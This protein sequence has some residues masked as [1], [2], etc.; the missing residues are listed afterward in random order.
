[1][2]LRP[3]ELRRRLRRERVGAP[4]AVRRRRPLRD[5]RRPRP[6]AARAAPSHRAVHDPRPDRSHERAHRW[7]PEPPRDRQALARAPAHAAAPPRRGRDDLQR[8]PRR[9]APFTGAPAPRGRTAQ[10]RRDRLPARVLATERVRPRL[11][12]LDRD[13]AEPAPGARREV[14]EAR[15]P[16]L[17]SRRGYPLSSA[18]TTSR[19]TTTHIEVPQPSD[20]AGSSK[21]VLMQ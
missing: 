6:R 8:G 4:D 5:P 10:R 11:P 13:D 18:V 9:G 19:A 15:L 3:A 7:R 12:A 14:A 2:P 1:G 20:E 16:S 17:V 21:G